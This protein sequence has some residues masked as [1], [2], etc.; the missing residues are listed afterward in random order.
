MAGRPKKGRKR[1]LRGIG[2]PIYAVFRVIG[3]NVLMANPNQ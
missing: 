3:Q 1:P 2:L